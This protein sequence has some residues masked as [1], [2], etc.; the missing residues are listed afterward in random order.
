MSVPVQRRKRKMNFKADN[1]QA[2]AGLAPGS[3]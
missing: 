1:G 2:T 3:G